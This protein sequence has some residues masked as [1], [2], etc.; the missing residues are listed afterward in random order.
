MPHTYLNSKQ[1]PAFCLAIIEEILGPFHKLLGHMWAKNGRHHFLHDILYHRTIQATALRVTVHID[2]V[3]LRRT[4][5]ILLPIQSMFYS[6]EF[7][8]PSVDL[9]RCRS[10]FI[11]QTILCSSAF[12]H[13][14]F[15]ALQAKSSSYDAFTRCCAVR[16]GPVMCCSVAADVFHVLGFCSDT[17]LCPS[18]LG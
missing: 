14:P 15:Y 18:P 5:N 11:S 12:Q 3:Q 7:F 16:A 10:T 9:S 1:C 2:T 17:R 6:L 4:S 13:V 8:T